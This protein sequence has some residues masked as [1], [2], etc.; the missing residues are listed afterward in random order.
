M[1]CILHCMFYLL[2]NE[3]A[4]PRKEKTIYQKTRHYILHISSQ[5][6][7]DI[8]NSQE[9]RQGDMRQMCRTLLMVIGQ[10]C[11]KEDRSGEKPPKQNIKA[12]A[13]WHKLEII[14]LNYIKICCAFTT[15]LYTQGDFFFTGTPL[16]VLST[17][18]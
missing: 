14:R 9:D 18:K 17:E 11:A 10:P 4:V 8:L 2:L 12:K 7:V 16:K 3:M 5:A 15:N 1:H 6:N 13:C